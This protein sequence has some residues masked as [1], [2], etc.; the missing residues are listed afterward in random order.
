LPDEEDH[1]AGGGSGGAE[2][3]HGAGAGGGAPPQD[4]RACAAAGAT[5]T[6]PHEVYLLPARHQEGYVAGKALCSA[7]GAVYM[8]GRG[9]VA[10]AGT[11]LVP[12]AHFIDRDRHPGLAEALGDAVS[13]RDKENAAGKKTARST[14]PNS[15][16]ESRLK[17]AVC[18][19]LRYNV[20]FLS[21][22]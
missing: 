14:S 17:K 2:E 13:S 4:R 22:K 1:G 19:F 11:D 6:V 5:F 18:L 8:V 21:D 12:L 3:D 15:S 20:M 9:V 10:S 7:Q 16:E